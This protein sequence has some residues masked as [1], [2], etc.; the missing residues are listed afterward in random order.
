[1]FDVGNPLVGPFPTD[2]L[3]VPDP[4]QKTGLKVNLPLPPCGDQPSSCAEI[5]E[6]NRL[7]GFSLNPRTTIRFSAPVN[8]HSVEMGVHFVWLDNLTAEEPG[9]RP[10]GHTTQINQ[11]VYDPA[12][13]TAHFKPNEVFDQHRRY[14]LVV[15]QD[16][17][18]E[19][20]DAVERDPAFDACITQPAG[21]YCG[22]LSAAVLALD[23][24]SFVVAASLFTTLSATAWLEG[25]RDQVGDTEP[26]F[27]PV[28]EPNVYQ[29]R[30][31]LAIT[32]RTET[33]PG[34]FDDFTVPQPSLFLPNIDRIAFGVYESP[35]Y[36]DGNQLIP[37]APTGQPPPAAN[38]TSNVFFQV[39]L[40]AA[41]PPAQGYPVAI[42]AHGLG[43][44]RLGGPVLIANGLAAQGFATLAITAVGHGGGPNS[45]VRLTQTAGGT[46]ELPL[47]GRSIDRNGDGRIEGREGCI[48]FDPAPAGIRDCLRQTVVDL[49]QLVR[50]IQSGLDIDGT[51]GSPLDAGRIYF[52]G[53]SLGALTGSLLH[54]IE[55]AI[56]AAV[57]N[58]GGGSVVDISRHSEGLGDIAIDFLANR[59]P[60]LLND[61]GAFNDDYPIRNQPPRVISVPG[62]LAIQTVVE[63]AEWV[64]MPGDPLAFATHLSRSSL[65][66]VPAKATLFQIALGDTTVPNPENSALVRAAGARLSTQVYRHDL[67]RAAVPSLRENPH[68]SLRENPDL[69][70]VPRRIRGPLRC[71]RRSLSGG[72]TNCLFHGRHDHPE[73]FDIFENGV[74]S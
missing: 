69:A 53:Q 6:V 18:D 3:T 29:F 51:G 56:R 32:I 50:L 52:A 59:E 44:S 74:F 63:R 10:E 49:M 9:L 16:V 7:D 45:I 72:G 1:M 73:P 37:A 17:R 15:T 62:A 5:G 13:N 68:A 71:G 30:N 14:L 23:D 58:V 34:L 22:R 46:V 66:G 11:L 36:L 4:T 21:D 61:N 25:A 55:P 64:Q 54:A 48:V 57:L 27:R 35:N 43:D 39:V 60:A 70:C 19:Q 12:T 41:A 24:P 8:L 2:A 28:G 31:L 40:P 47:G 42:V 20:G 38:S 26:N 67:A 33:G 65:P